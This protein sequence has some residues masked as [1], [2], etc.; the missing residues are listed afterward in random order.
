VKK[1]LKCLYPEVDGNVIKNDDAKVVN[2]LLEH[3]PQLKNI[4]RARAVKILKNRF[5]DYF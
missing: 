2:M 4:S 1:G 3:N 5:P